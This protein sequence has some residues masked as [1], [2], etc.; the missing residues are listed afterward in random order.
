MG[1]LETP[2]ESCVRHNYPILVEEV[3]VILIPLVPVNDTG[4]Q[5]SAEDLQNIFTF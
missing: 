1:P 5:T 4:F 2:I 3:L